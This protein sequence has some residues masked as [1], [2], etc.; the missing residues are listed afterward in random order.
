M[1]ASSPPPSSATPE[2]QRAAQPLGRQPG[3]P[4]MPA[5]VKSP[6]PA[7]I[8]PAAAARSPSTSSA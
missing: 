6:K 2:E 7:S 1:A 4:G 5:P 3:A 8:T